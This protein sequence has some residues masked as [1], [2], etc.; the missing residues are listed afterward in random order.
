MLIDGDSVKIGPKYFSSE[1]IL[2]LQTLNSAVQETTYDILME[3]NWEIL[4]CAL[5]YRP[6]HTGVNQYSRAGFTVAG[7]Y[8]NSVRHGITHEWDPNSN[9][10]YWATWKDG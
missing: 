2:R 4:S 3:L 10:Y 8:K 9:S 7:T 1:E 5:E 6:D